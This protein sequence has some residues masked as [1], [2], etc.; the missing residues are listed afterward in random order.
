MAKKKKLLIR[1]KKKPALFKWGPLSRKQVDVLTWWTA[2]SKYKDYNGIILDGSVRSGKTVSMG[3]SFVLW[4]METYDR[5]NFALCGK[6]IESFRRNVW[7]TLKQ[8]LKA[9][10]YTVTEKRSENLIVVS[11]GSKANLFYIFGG[12][13]E[14]SQDLIQGITLAGL[15]CDE[16]ALMPE[17]FVNQ[18]TARC[19]VAGSK[20][21]F[22]CNP[23]GPMHWFY[24]NWLL[25]CRSRKL[26]YLHFTMAD[27]LTLAKDIVDRY[28][29]QFSGV[30]FQR[31]ILGLWVAAEGLIY[32]MFSKDQHVIKQLPDLTGPWYISSD[33]GINN[34]NCFLIWRKI[35]NTDKWC[36]I[37]EYYYDGRKNRKQK[38]VTELVDALDALVKSVCKCKPEGIEQVIID[39]SASAMKV[40]LQKRGY[41]TRNADND[42]LAGIQDVQMMLL[43]D[44][45]KFMD[46]CK[47]TISEFQMYVWDEKKAQKGEDAV[48]KANDHGMDA[49]RYFVRT[50]GFVKWVEDN[51]DYRSPLEDY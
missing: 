11:K 33:F 20:F 1:R 44:R 26:V 45:L 28:M 15:L 12:K 25:R 8:Q 49:V 13:D 3:F 40:E 42:V 22:N 17:S 46:C 9:R 2:D 36:C 38:T 14:G 19:S 31:Y 35:R 30:F 5:Q 43:A 24:V 23:A 6:T 21:W 37:H 39:P 10:G 41:N 47:S 48:I 18:A 16:V 7:G 4:A 29:S 32:D 27:N 34:P 50:M 51:T